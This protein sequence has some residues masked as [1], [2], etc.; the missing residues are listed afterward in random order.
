MP[1]DADRIAALGRTVTLIDGTAVAVRFDFAA[2]RR[3]EHRFGSVQ[4]TAGALARVWGVSL[5]GWGE[6]VLDDLDGLYVAAIG[7]S[8]DEVA[9]QPNVAVAILVDAWL[10]AFPGASEGKAEGAETVTE[11]SPGPSS[12]TSSPSTGAA[13]TASSGG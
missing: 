9:E 12:T 3:A 7:R 2:L 11:P 4:A 6:G 8:V 13:V 1:S 5:D 10:E